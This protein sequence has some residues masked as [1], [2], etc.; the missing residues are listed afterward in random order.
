MLTS[1]P[2]M[3]FFFLWSWSFLSC[4][5][6]SLFLPSRPPRTPACYLHHPP[7]PAALTRRH[8]PPLTCRLRPQPA[9]TQVG[10]WSAEVETQVLFLSLPSVFKQELLC[11]R[12]PL[13]AHITRGFSACPGPRNW[14]A[15]HE[16]E[17]GAVLGQITVSSR[18][19]LMDRRRK[20]RMKGM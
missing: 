4:F 10:V 9:P 3:I 16:S 13:R 19:L 14:T 17:P 6:L 12:L 20:R 18:Q 7:R 5:A 11:F 15:E 2:Q 8:T 1:V